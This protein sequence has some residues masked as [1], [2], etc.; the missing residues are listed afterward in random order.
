[1]FT[2]RNQPEEAQT[3]AS[4]GTNTRYLTELD[5]WLNENVY[6]P[7]ESTVATSDTRL[8]LRKAEIERLIT[9]FVE[10]SANLSE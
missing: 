9:H 6:E 1:M 2:R 8:A 10:A 5:Q 4:T 3:K 7:I